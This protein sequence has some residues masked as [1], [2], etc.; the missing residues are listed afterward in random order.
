VGDETG[1]L[2]EPGSVTDRYEALRAA[3]LTAAAD[4]FRHG[5]GLLLSKGLVAWM[6]VAAHAPE[7]AAREIAEP[8]AGPALAGVERELVRVLAGIALASIDR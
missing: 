3:A 2:I 6:A 5:L 4:G 7:R 1:T 8:T